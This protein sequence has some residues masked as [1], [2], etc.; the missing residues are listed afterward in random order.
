MEVNPLY[1]KYFFWVGKMLGTGLSQFQSLDWFH[2]S[3]GLLLF[4]ADLG[5]DPGESEMGTDYV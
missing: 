1:S 3:L 4:W 5:V 2:I